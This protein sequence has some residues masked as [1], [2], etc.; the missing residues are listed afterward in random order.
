MSH[1]A[2][3]EGGVSRELEALELAAFEISP[4]RSVT[5]VNELACE[6]Y[7]FQRPAVVGRPIAEVLRGR[8]GD[9]PWSQRLT[10]IGT[11][12]GVEDH[13]RHHGPHVWVEVAVERCGEGHRLTCRRASALEVVK[14]V[15]GPNI[16]LTR[17]AF[18]AGGLG[19]WLD[20]RLTGALDWSPR[21][22]E[23]FGFSPDEAVT[24]DRFFQHIHPDD[25]A[26]FGAAIQT[27]IV[28]GEPVDHTMRV[29]DADGSYRHV[30]TFGTAQ[31]TDGGELLLGVGGC[32]DVD[33]RVRLEQ[34]V[35]EL[36]QQVRHAQKMEAV[37][38]LAS[39][40]AHD[41]NNLLTTILC[42][43]ELIA[44]GELDE[45]GRQST[46][47][48]QSAVARAAELT[49]QLLAY[50]RKQ[51]MTLQVV[52]LDELIESSQRLL[53]RLVGET[54]ELEFFG[55]SKAARVSIDPAQLHQVLTNLVINAAHAMPNGGSTRIDTQLVDVVRDDHRG[56]YVALGVRDN[57]RGIA[58]EMLP[59]IFEPFF[60]TKEVGEGTGLGL[61]TVQG[62]VAQ[63]GG[64]ID[65]DSE[66]GVGTTFLIHL[67][68]VDAALD[69]SP[70]RA[71]APPVAL[72]GKTVIVVEDDEM[73][74][75]IV[76]RL[77]E[78]EGM[79]VIA[80]RTG[81]DALDVT[82]APPSP[83]IVITDVVMPRMSGPELVAALRKRGDKSRVVY[84]SGYPAEIIDSRVALG[85]S[86]TLLHKP[87]T[88]EALLDALREL[89]AR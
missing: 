41:F 18:E 76:K 63:L 44:T 58:P 66:V 4:S 54:V 50:S 8:A 79:H 7:G 40:I 55:G 60:T 22:R 83:D 32:E 48:V 11:W 21:A 62:I 6:L 86:E 33:E 29:V 69:I 28:N 17:R 23:V 70:A 87:F 31:R 52:C 27:A 12:R 65:V 81:A 9:L 71:P 67:P 88:S 47:D 13:V 5:G 49:Q 74:R 72:Q 75:T 42:N 56:S 68:T 77:L 80:T 36:E 35:I 2:R 46:Q 34:R 89:L 10:Q 15:S 3:S 45:L 85:P 38:R 51:P 24:H 59:H 84:M 61:S 25:R 39:G 82:S 30:R 57:G 43:T 19:S 64:F 37:G 1:E 14:A 53:Q 20:D 78:R 16:D 26:P 73:I